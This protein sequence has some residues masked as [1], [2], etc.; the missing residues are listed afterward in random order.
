MM[1]KNVDPKV[2]VALGIGFAA[3]AVYTFII[4]Q[5]NKGMIAD[6][7]RTVLDD[8]T[9]VYPGEINTTEDEEIED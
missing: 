8:L 1:L 3:G 6:E 9:W 5:A 7:L 2:V 4:L